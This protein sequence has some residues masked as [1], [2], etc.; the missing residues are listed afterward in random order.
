MGTQT[1]VTQR[2]TPGDMSFLILY[3]MGKQDYKACLQEQGSSRCDGCP[4]VGDVALR[5]TL[6]V[7]GDPECLLQLL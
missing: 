7:C 6:P 3:F 1:M 4:T 2:L 5:L